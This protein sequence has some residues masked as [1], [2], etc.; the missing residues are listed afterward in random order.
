MKDDSAIRQAIHVF[1]YPAN[2]RQ[3]NESR[4]RPG[5]LDLL[6]VAAG[7]QET[8][9]RL[10]EIENV[11]Q[12]VV[13]EASKHYL[14]GLITDSKNNP[15]TTLG[16]SA[17]ATPEEIK[18]HKRW[19]LKWLHPDRNPSKWEAVL[20]KKVSLAAEALEYPSVVITHVKVKQRKSN[21]VLRREIGKVLHHPRRTASKTAIFVAFLKPVLFVLIVAVAASM[22]LKQF[23]S[24]PS[25][26]SLAS[27]FM[28][29]FKDE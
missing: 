17:A 8:I 28:A 26:T 6:K 3:R 14:R 11:T 1:K 27:Q 4:V 22:T 24:P 23:S 13:C 21:S 18:T 7:H 16:L 9:E 5:M 29:K 2:L 25:S 19:L 15:Y 10:S 20:F 12:E